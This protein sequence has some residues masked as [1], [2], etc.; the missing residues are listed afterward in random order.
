MEE[1]SLK[2]QKSQ[3]GTAAR[4]EARRV[5]LGCVAVQL[6]KVKLVMERQISAA[7]FDSANG[8]KKRNK[9]SW[10]L[11]FYFCDWLLVHPSCVQWWSGL[12]KED[13]MRQLKTANVTCCF[14]ESH[15]EVSDLHCKA[16]TCCSL[17]SLSH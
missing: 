1:L 4:L 5:H 7:Q 13:N 10:L 6:T 16:S 9:Y 12:L 15:I 11:V 8:E 17:H 3:D 14:L 2:L